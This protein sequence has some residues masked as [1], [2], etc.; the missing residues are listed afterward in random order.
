M[1]RKISSIAYIQLGEVI[2]CD[3]MRI[4]E[5]NGNSIWNRNNVSEM[6]YE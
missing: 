2:Y 3:Y 1:H 4:Q 6:I 5:E